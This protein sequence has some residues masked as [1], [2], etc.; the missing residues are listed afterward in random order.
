MENL[1]YDH[2]KDGL[3]LYNKAI[4]RINA[5]EYEKT[6]AVQEPLKRTLSVS[7]KSEKEEDDM[8][9]LDEAAVKAKGGWKPLSVLEVSFEIIP[10]VLIHHSS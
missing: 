3:E 9:D 5:Y 8:S 10:H 7:G 4:G 6:A 1:T 2:V